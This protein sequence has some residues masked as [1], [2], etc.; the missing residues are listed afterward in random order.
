MEKAVK[1]EKCAKK[2]VCQNCSYYSR[3]KKKCTQHRAFTPRKGT[4]S[5]FSEVNK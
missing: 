2:E 1:S 3:E 5:D 4:C